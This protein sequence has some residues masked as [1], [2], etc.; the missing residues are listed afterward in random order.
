MQSHCLVW[1]PCLAGVASPTPQDSSP[2]LTA[3]LAAPGNGLALN[4]AEN[5]L[6]FADGNTLRALTILSQ[7]PPMPNPPPVPPMP[8]PPPFRESLHHV[9][10]G[11]VMHAM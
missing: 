1:P 2:A 9:F 4:M 6:Y 11:Y 3:V 8:V 7:A 10:A 5:Q